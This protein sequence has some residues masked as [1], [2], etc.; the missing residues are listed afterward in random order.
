M[1]H[2]GPLNLLP[3]LSHAKCAESLSIQAVKTFIL[4]STWTLEGALP[5]QPLLL[6][7]HVGAVQ[8]PHASAACMTFCI[9]PSALHYLAFAEWERMDD[10]R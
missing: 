2:A 8:L 7:R 10:L 1:T 3:W 5:S 6:S 4:P 9:W